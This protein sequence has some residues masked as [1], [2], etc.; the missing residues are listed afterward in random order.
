MEDQQRRGGRDQDQTVRDGVELTARWR[1]SPCAACDQAVE[2][3]S[4]AREQ[5]HSSGRLAMCVPGQP[6]HD[7][8]GP[9]SHTAQPVRHAEIHCIGRSGVGPQV[10]RPFDP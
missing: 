6:D 8:T 7:R 4:E 5:K 3:V 10:C 2:I 1:L 9:D